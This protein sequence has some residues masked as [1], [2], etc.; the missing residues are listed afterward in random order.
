MIELADV[1]VMVFARAPEAG[2]VKTRLTPAL[3][4]QGAA[5]LYARFVRQAVASAVGAGLGPVTLWTTPNSRNLFFAGLKQDYPIAFADQKGADLGKRMSFAFRQC[6]LSHP[7]ALLMGTDCP[8]LT[9]ADL[10]SAARALASG[11]DA[12]LIPALDGG[13]VLLGLRVPAPGLFSQVPWGTD[14]VLDATRRRLRECSL[15]WK[16]LPA[17]RDI[18]R[19]ADLVFVESDLLAG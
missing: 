8:S 3:G 16:E 5:D 1:P 17:R 6:L 4:E 10:R 13:Y 12:V 9:G 15:R 7:A 2:K 19:P 18:D 11:S 14:A